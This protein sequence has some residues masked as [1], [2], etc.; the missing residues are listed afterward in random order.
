MPAASAQKRARQ[1]ANKVSQGESTTSPTQTPE[2]TSPPAQPSDSIP[3]LQSSAPPSSAAIDF[4]T[5]I[6]FCDLDDI[7]RF[8][9]S[10][11]SKPEGRNLKLIWDRAFKE[12]N[13]KGWSARRD[14]SDEMYL[15]GKEMGI[16]E[17]EEA[18]DRAA[19]DFYHHGIE[20]GKTEERSEWT[21]KGH[22][23]HC[24]SPIAILDSQGS[25]TDPEPP[26]TLIS[27]QTSTIS[28]LKTSVQAS[29][30]PPSPSQPQKVISKP[31][32]WAD[33]TYSPQII[34]LPTQNLPSPLLAR[35]FSGLRS[36]NSNPFSSL[37]HRSKRSNHYSHHSHGR[38]SRFNS[39]SFYSPHYNPLKRSQPHFSTKTYSHLNWEYDPRLSDLSRSLK[40]L[41]W[42]RAHWYHSF[43]SFF[44]SFFCFDCEFALFLDTLIFKFTFFFFTHF[45]G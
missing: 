26:T 22:G 13:N 12:G 7:H 45:S 30:P 1:R 34:P 11:A 16:K 14:F 40:A 15:R 41:G 38:H 20:K 5:F 23:P 19:I 17:T 9:D 10:V 36:S 27:T 28:H 44:F 25:Q 39:N 18:A 43:L 35:D 6:K 31:F 42:I 21:S 32:N 4:E 24:L 29:E 33:D 2:I 3:V 37:Q 8:F